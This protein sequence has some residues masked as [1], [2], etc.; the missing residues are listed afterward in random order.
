MI[1]LP[2]N[3]V[4]KIIDDAK[5]L[6]AYELHKEKMLE[7]TNHEFFKFPDLLSEE[8]YIF[9]CNGFLNYGS[10]HP[11]PFD[12]EAC[13]K[14]YLDFDEDWQLRQS[15]MENELRMDLEKYGAGYIPH[16]DWRKK[17]SLHYDLGVKTM[18]R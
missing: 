18:T 10:D 16:F 7:I 1:L 13:I 3:L 2:T 15:S 8:I 5:D 6:E 4:I 14:S 17:E 12:I 9:K 11:D